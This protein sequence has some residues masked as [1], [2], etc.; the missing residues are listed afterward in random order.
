[1]FDGAWRLASGQLPWRDF[2][3]PNGVTPIVMQA[4]IFQL[5]GV[6]WT[7]YVLHAAAVNAAAAGLVYLFMR[8]I[9]HARS[10]SLGLGTLTAATLYP[11][12]GTPYLESHSLAFSLVAVV[13][14]Y[15]AAVR[16]PNVWVALI[17]PAAL[18]AAA[19]SKQIPAVFFLPLAFVLPALYSQQRVKALAYM[20]AGFGAVTLVVSLIGFVAGVSAGSFWEYYVSVPLGAGGRR[21]T[22]L[23]ILFISA[24]G[25]A[26]RALPLTTLIL[27]GSLVAAVVG[28][29]GARRATRSVDSSFDLRAFVPSWSSSWCAVVSSCS[30]AVS[31]WAFTALTHNATEQSLGLLPLA[32]GLALAAAMGS[33]AG[34]ARTRVGV[35]LAAMMLGEAMV[36]HRSVNVTRATHEMDVQAGWSTWSSD[37]SVPSAM[38]Q[39]GFARWAVPSHYTS[40]A[41]A[42]AQ[43]VDV[44]RTQP[45][46]ILMVGDETIIYGLTGKP[47]VTSFLWFHPGLVWE[48]DAASWRDMEDALINNLDRYDVT[49][50]II[51]A[52]VGWAFWQ[53]SSFPR[54]AARVRSLTDCTMAGSY[55]ICD[56]AP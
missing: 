55:R 42:F 46:N 40:T 47:S 8:G 20:A 2:V 44:V 16:P 10:V 4:L 5:L 11:P 27:V 17:V 34:P 14:S 41:S 51:P 54:L 12:V 33:A 1:M 22:G 23:G 28:A 6:S 18:A 48:N 30:I 53:I 37:A 24:I 15:Y 9:G 36:F 38:R 39:T 13:G 7:S 3:L 45:E 52:N 25:D 35:V 32:A 26:T 21:T 49:K 29:V 19:L 50:V 43:L 56:L 31:T